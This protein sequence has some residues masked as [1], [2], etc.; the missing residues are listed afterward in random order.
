MKADAAGEVPVTTVCPTTMSGRAAVAVLGTPVQPRCDIKGTGPVSAV[1]R[2]EVAIA[3]VDTGTEVSQVEGIEV[4]VCIG[5]T[6]EVTVGG[7]DI[8]RLIS[9]N[10]T[11]AV[12]SPA[13][14]ALAIPAD[15]SW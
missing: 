2:A 1:D 10:E 3:E 11:S 14:G 7:R 5:A 6:I 12:V 8:A 13:G 9:A 4:T 15:T